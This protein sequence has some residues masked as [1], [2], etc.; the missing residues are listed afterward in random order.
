[1]TEILYYT[2]I[3]KSY[4]DQWHF[5][6][7]MLMWFDASFGYFR[8]IIL[9]INN[10]WHILIL[11]TFPRLS[12][13]LP[14]PKEPRILNCYNNIDGDLAFLLHVC[15]NYC[16][17]SN[18]PMVLVLFCCSSIKCFR[19]YFESLTNSATFS[20]MVTILNQTIVQ[21]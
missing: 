3:S 6:R 9:H 21:I 2:S 4:L 8:N 13:S 1:M 11:S 19:C 10:A 5:E 16:K 17:I 15:L 20:T 18:I 7:C 14:P 12:L